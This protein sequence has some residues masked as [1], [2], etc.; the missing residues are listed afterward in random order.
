MLAFYTLNLPMPS[1]AGVFLADESGPA[2]VV[3][4]QALEEEQQRMVAAPFEFARGLG[5]L[6]PFA[7]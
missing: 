6:I 7:V 1:R 2:R 4:L 5:G 3:G